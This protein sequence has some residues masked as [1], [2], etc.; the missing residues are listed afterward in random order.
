[1]DPDP[2][3]LLKPRWP[4]AALTGGEWSYIRKEGNVYEELF[5]IKEDAQE[6]HN[7]V[8]DPD[9]QPVLERMRKALSELT[10]GPL[11]PQRFNP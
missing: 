2:A 8:K 6:R 5:H 11:T 7:L 9:S 3:R 10:A 4:L 1:M